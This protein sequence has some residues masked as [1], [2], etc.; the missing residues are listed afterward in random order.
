M[1]SVPPPPADLDKQLPWASDSQARGEE[2][3]WP[4]E[5]ALKG[6]QSQN[7]MLAL[8]VIGIV[9]AI[10]IVFFSLVFLGSLSAWLWHQLAP[11][12]RHWLSDAQLSKIQSV[13][14]S[15]AIGAIVSGYVQRHISN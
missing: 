4:D 13:I 10:L 3:N 8:K 7:D 11:V 2:R 1:S 9:T 15:G 6:Q 12:S 5:E 14:F